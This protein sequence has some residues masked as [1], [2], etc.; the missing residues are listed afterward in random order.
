MPYRFGV[1]TLVKR[2]KD[3]TVILDDSDLDMNEFYSD[4]KNDPNNKRKDNKGNK[5]EKNSN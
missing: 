2:N 5:D 1:V 4:P 3:K